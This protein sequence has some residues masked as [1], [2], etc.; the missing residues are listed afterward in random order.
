V[1]ITKDL[2]IKISN[3]EAKLNENV[4]IYQ[5]DRGIE[6]KLKLNLISTN[7]RSAI[8]SSLFETSVI[9]AGATI[10]KPNGEVIGRDRTVVEDDTITFKIDKDFTDHV[11]EIGVYKIQ[12]HLYDT[13]DNRLT[14][15]PIEFEVKELLG[16]INEDDFELKDGIVDSSFSD[17]CT[18]GDDGREVEIFSNGKYIKTV[19]NSG[20]LI[21]SVKL[22]KIE[23]AIEYLDNQ[24]HIGGEPLYEPMIWIDV[25]DLDNSSLIIDNTLYKNKPK[26][27]TLKEQVDFLDVKISDY[28]EFVANGA[29]NTIINKSLPN[30]IKEECLSC[31]TSVNVNVLLETLNN[32]TD[33]VKVLEEEI[34][35]IKNNN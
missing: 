21:T 5:N 29:L 1:S 25:P 6:L 17:L 4:Y 14:I 31:I 2:E 35:L 9:F 12:F 33:R 18:V 30:K 26:S 23:E 20:D 27:T 19:W 16:I 32:I 3:G 8:K 28:T 13:E 10:L 11:D 24:F 34:E 7:Y 15:P 22:N